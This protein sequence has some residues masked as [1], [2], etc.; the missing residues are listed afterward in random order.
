MS[1]PEGSGEWSEHDVTDPGGVID[2]ADID[3]C[4]IGKADR[5]KGAVELRVP[6]I[7]D[8]GAGNGG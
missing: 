6:R 7:P 1:V 5:I 8:D 2:V 4:L 3:P